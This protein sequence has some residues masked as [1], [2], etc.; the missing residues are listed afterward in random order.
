MR[1]S[2][3]RLS[4]RRDPPS[5]PDAGGPAITAISRTSSFG[6]VSA[7]PFFSTTLT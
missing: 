5:L 1:Y 2:N 6:V 7:D 3:F 4:P